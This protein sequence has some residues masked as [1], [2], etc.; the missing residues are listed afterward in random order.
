[1]NKDSPW[2]KLGI[3]VEL[4]SCLTRQILIEKYCPEK[5]KGIEMA[6]FFFSKINGC[7]LATHEA[8]KN[9]IFYIK[10]KEILLEK[11]IKNKY[12]YIKYTNFWSIFESKYKVDYADIQSLTRDRLE[13]ALKLEGYKTRKQFRQSSFQLEEALKLEGYKTDTKYDTIIIPVG[14]SPKIGRL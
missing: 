6:N 11:D 12:F 2:T 1:M 9:Y 7:E 3:N 14:G 4:D 8:Y 5:A 10:N 13:E